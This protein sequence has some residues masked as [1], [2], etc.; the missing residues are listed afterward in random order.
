MEQ[1]FPPGAWWP[2]R[3]SSPVP[4]STG[5]DL[6]DTV[7]QWSPRLLA[8][9]MRRDRIPAPP[10]AELLSGD[11][12]EEVGDLCSRWYQ[13]PDKWK[14]GAAR[15]L[16]CE[17]IARLTEPGAGRCYELRFDE[18]L[19]EG[20][21]PI[22]DMHRHL[23]DPHFLDIN[24]S[25][26][27]ISGREVFVRVFWVPETSSIVDGLELVDAAP[28]A[29]VGAALLVEAPTGQRSVSPAVVAMRAAYRRLAEAGEITLSTKQTQRYR[30]V[31]ESAEV[32]DYIRHSEGKR[33]LSD[34][35]FG[36]KVVVADWPLKPTLA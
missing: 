31:Y 35:N 32:T 27:L 5:W 21:R 30:L 36:R 16:A 25:T 13:L 23:L 22:A 6:L 12:G 17:L 26:A 14:F 9:L 7:R 3:A 11:I 29:E 20:F 18:G 28:S 15:N 19:S 33:G 4:P 1:Q 2:R 8:M 34:D 10:T 24:A